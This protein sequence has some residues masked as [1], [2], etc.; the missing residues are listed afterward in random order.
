M[1]VVVW[2]GAV[3]WWGG[4]VTAVVVWCGAVCGRQAAL[5]AAARHGWSSLTARR[6]GTAAAQL[7]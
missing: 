1:A 4:C 5:P 3:W 2:C 7:H 6:L